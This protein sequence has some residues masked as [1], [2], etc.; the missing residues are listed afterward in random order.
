[1]VYCSQQNLIYVIHCHLKSCVKIA[2]GQ[3][4]TCS[5]FRACRRAQQSTHIWS[6]CTR[7]FLS[8]CC[9]VVERCVRNLTAKKAEGACVDGVS[10]ITA[11][12]GCY[13]GHICYACF[14]RQCKGSVHR[15][16]AQSSLLLS[17]SSL[18]LCIGHQ[19][20]LEPSL[21]GSIASI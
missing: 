19:R 15:S 3:A 21:R 16:A 8:L 6:L 17:Y 13:P 20:K 11:E 7:V 1:M 12:G 4:Y 10:D 9:K 18:T 5:S 2:P 14:G